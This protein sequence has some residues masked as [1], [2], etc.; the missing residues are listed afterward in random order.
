M[1]SREAAILA[2]TED[3]WEG[4]SMT[5]RPTIDEFASQQSRSLSGGRSRASDVVVVSHN[6]RRG[7]LRS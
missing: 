6:S 1:N 4:Q 3:S 2:A 7:A 5:V